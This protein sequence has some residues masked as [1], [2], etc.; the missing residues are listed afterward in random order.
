LAAIIRA[1]SFASRSS[2][3]GVGDKAGEG[4]TGKVALGPGETTVGG[5]DC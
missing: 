3:G 5:E 2:S 4:G 1:F